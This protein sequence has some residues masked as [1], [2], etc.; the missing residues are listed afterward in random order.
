ML[1][2]KRNVWQWHFE[3]VRHGP[4][5]VNKNVGERYVRERNNEEI[6]YQSLR[7]SVQ[8]LCGCLLI[9]ALIRKRCLG[10]GYRRG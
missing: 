8:V 3:S 2:C 10:H 6:A 7:A 5:G 1:S 9:A 4:L